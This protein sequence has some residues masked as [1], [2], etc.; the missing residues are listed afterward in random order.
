MI[1]GKEMERQKKGILRF[2]ERTAEKLRYLR[3][4]SSTRKNRSKRTSQGP[5]SPNLLQSPAISEARISTSSTSN[6]TGKKKNN[7]MN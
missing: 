6:T 2:L 7:K 4:S 5:P 1:K 3:L